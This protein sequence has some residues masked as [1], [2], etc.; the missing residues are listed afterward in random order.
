MVGSL[1]DLLGRL[2]PDE[3]RQKNGFSAEVESAHQQL[4]AGSPEKSELQL[5]INEWLRSHQPCLFGKAAA[6]VKAIHYCILS[7]ADLEK[8]DDVVRDAIRDNHLD[9]TRAAF[10]GRSSSF[11]LLVVSPR[12]AYARPSAHVLEFAARL[13]QLYLQDDEIEPDRIHHDAVY[14]AIPSRRERVL[15][16]RAGV[17]YFSART[18]MDAGGAITGFLAVLGSQRTRSAT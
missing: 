3:W 5:V 12:L 4:F 16:W 6:T 13:A 2:E 8:G 7:E 18:G 10:E 1:Y 15:K 17:N 9:W 14:L 11:V